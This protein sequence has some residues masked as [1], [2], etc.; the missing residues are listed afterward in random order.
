MAEKAARKRGFALAEQVLEQLPT[1]VMAVDR[2]LRIL[3]VNAAGRRFVGKSQE[4]L[5]GRVCGEIFGT[6]HCG[7]PDCCMRRAMEEGVPRSARNEVP[8]N[9]ERVPIEYYTAPLRDEEGNVIGGLEY[10][11][12][13]TERVRG[14]ERL[15]EQARTIREI[16][17][18]AIR[19]W[20]GIV[21]LPVVGVVDSLRAQQMMDTMLTKIAETACRV[22]ILDIQGVPAVDTA[23]ANHLIKIVKATRLMGCQPIISGISPAVAQ[24]IVHLGIDMGART[25]ATLCDALADAFEILR[26]EVRRARPDGSGA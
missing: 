14:E 9:G 2:D 22:I 17:T 12:D 20:E 25:T 19:L 1:P 5:L 24:T 11:L 4:E 16:S 6:L 23:V 10:V 7:T 13:I 26:F 18:P 8:L 3:Y 21:M 15:R